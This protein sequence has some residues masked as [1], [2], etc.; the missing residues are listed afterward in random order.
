MSVLKPFTMPTT[1][2]VS[3]PVV[4]G[5]KW[6]ECENPVGGSG[7]RISRRISVGSKSTSPP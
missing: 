6:A 5:E 7:S 3:S 2:F 4:S 1:G